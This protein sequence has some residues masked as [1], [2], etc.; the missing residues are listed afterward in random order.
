M[1]I[2]LN[3]LAEAQAAEE[4]RRRDPVKRAAWVSALIIVVTLVWSSS[5]QFKAILINS[6]V[7]R[8]EAQIKSQAN[9]YRQILDHQNRAADTK[10]KLEALRNL[11]AN[12]HL[13]GRP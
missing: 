9:E 11:S 7:S 6:E 13:Q 10:N 1:P 2:R 4:A 5:L 12:R 3:L 8:L